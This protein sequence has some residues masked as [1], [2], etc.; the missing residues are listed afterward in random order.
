MVKIKRREHLRA[1]FSSESDCWSTPQYLFDALDLEFNFSLDATA[2][3]ENTK[4]LSFISPEQDALRQS[5]NGTVWLNPPYGRAIGK[6]IQKAVEE[7]TRGATVVCLV[8]ARTDSKWFN[9]ALKHADELR[10]IR[11]RLKFGNAGSSI[12]FRA[13]S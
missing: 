13:S 2:T 10:F 4:C 3:A 8:P 9:L 5:W 12:H 1:L 7:A 6:F 11:G